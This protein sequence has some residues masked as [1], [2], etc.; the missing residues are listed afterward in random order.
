[1]HTGAEGPQ[2][3]QALNTLFWLP[4]SGSP[5]PLFRKRSPKTEVLNS[6]NA[7]DTSGKLMKSIHPLS[8]MVLF[9]YLFVFGDRVSCVDSVDQAGLELRNPPASA[10]QVLGSKVLPPLPGFSKFLKQNKT[11]FVTQAHDSNTLDAGAGSRPL[12]TKWDPVS[13]QTR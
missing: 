7:I 13:K 6:T 5:A 8:S 10:S 9:V 11:G 4:S 1:V 3:I 2:G 12:Y